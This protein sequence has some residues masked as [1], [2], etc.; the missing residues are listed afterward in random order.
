MSALSFLAQVQEPVSEVASQIEFN[1][2]T[3]SAI[4]AL[5]IPVLTGLITKSSAAVGIKQ[6]VT[7]FLAAVASLFSANVVGD[8]SAVISK[9]T[10][11]LWA[12]N[13]AIALTTY[14]GIYKPHAI[15]DR[16]V[17]DKG[18]G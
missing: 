2:L 8:G 15:D 10:F 9:E 3:V 16:L 1:A 7:I 6:G 5:F 11:L 4:L 14:V 13:T 18:F 17:P 12:M